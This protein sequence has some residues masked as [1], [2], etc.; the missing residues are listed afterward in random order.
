MCFSL[1]S[2]S[3][4]TDIVYL[5]PVKNN[6]SRH[7]NSSPSTQQETSPLASAATLVI[8]ETIPEEQFSVETETDAAQIVQI[9]HVGLGSA[10]GEKNVDLAT[11]MVRV[12]ART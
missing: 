5:H 8:S 6:T 9:Q 2:A 3:F 4:K 1:T 10:L 7:D 11:I 12:E